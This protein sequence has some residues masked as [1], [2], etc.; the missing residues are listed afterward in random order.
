M[1]YTGPGPFPGV[2]EDL[3]MSEEDE[4]AND[5]WPCLS[6]SAGQR[7]LPALVVPGLPSTPRSGCD[8]HAVSASK[9][10]MDDVLNSSGELQTPVSKASRLKEGNS[11]QC[12]DSRDTDPPL[13]MPLPSRPPPS[14]PPPSLP[15]FAP[16][17]EYLKL[18]FEDNPSVDVKL[19]WLAEVNR[20]FHLKRDL[21]EVKMSA[22]TSRFVYISRVRLDVVGSAMNG[23]FLALTL[24]PQ[25]SPDRTRK[26]PTYLVTRYPVGVDPSLSK[27]LDGVYSARRF[28]QDGKP[29]S[30]IVV[31]W[32][33]TDPPPSSFPFSFLPS[34]P[35]CE[36]RLLHNDKPSCFKCWGIGH[37]SRY[38][39]GPG[40]MCMVCWRSRLPHLPSPCPPT[41]TPGHW[42]PHPTSASC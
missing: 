7:Q 18:M 30:R 5:T 28:H 19:R 14:R 15:A 20:A 29:I 17:G 9:R 42:R 22:V 31:T 33:D 32:T 39:F 10:S 6:H 25:D 24:T 40:T 36:F 3:R 4:Q 38:C 11:D 34:L 21:A 12:S 35:P 16:R 2:E 23:D 37:I 27:E 41:T 1:S 26:L 13:P 8:P